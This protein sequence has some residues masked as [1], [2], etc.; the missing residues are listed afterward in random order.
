MNLIAQ[1]IQRRQRQRIN[2]VQPARVLGRVRREGPPQAGAEVQQDVGRL[3]DD[4]V[5]VLQDWRCEGRRVDAVVGGF[6]LDEGEDF[7]HAAVGEG[8]V[9]V[10][11]AGL[12]Q[13]EADVLAAAGDA[14]P[15]DELILVFGSH[16]WI[17]LSTGW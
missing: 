15:V 9:G 16:G 14:G 13:G 7:V 1:P 3:A 12:F 8:C 2:P 11:G 10:V 4:D 5:A 6:A 17:F